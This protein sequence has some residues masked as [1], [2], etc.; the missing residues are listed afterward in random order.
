MKTAP[1]EAGMIR[2]LRASDEVFLAK[3]QRLQDRMA[4]AHREIT[5]GVRVSS[6]LQQAGT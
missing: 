5:S 6:P 2:N 1:N 3:L 4:Q